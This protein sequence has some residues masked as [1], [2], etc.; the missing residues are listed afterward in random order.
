VN[1]VKIGKYRI[2][3]TL[4][5]GAM[6]VVYKGFD[7]A[8]QR[9]VAIKVLH[10]QN[11][12]G[13]QGKELEQRFQQEAQAAARCSH[14]NIVSIYEYGL[15]EQGAP[16]IAMEYV[17]GVE[18]KRYLK[19][20]QGDL[21]IGQSIEIISQV[22]QALDYAHQHKVIHRDIKPSN[23]ILT[24][25]HQ[26][27]VMDFGVAKLDTSDLTLVGYMVGTPSYMSPEGLRGQTVDG[28]SDLYSVGLVLLELLTGS[29]VK[30]GDRIN[31]QIPSLLERKVPPHP[32]RD[33]LCAL[34]IR[35]LHPEANQ[36]FQT[37]QALLNAI[38]QAMTAGTDA[39]Q[40][41]RDTYAGTVVVQRCAQLPPG[42]TSASS[43]NVLGMTGS[44]S[45]YGTRHS[46]IALSTQTLIQIE[47]TLASH[48][49][50]LAKVLIK[51]SLKST[52]CVKSFAESLAAHIPEKQERQSFLD[53][54]KR[55]G[56]HKNNSAVSRS[57][58]S[59][60]GHGLN[61]SGFNN[62]ELNSSG[63]S[64]SGASYTFSEPELKALEEQLAFYLG[65]LA[66]RMVRRLAKQSRSLEELKQRLSEKIPN[67]SE[68]T[69]FLAAD[70]S[71]TD[72]A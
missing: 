54:L 8:I 33:S 67:H 63:L 36:R 7:D 26:V 19:G 45:T 39:T 18:L 69:A 3:S 60:S 30:V 72:D 50:P 34:L 59:S 58:S 48:V 5:R 53:A 46:N 23:I 4:G 20:E 27:K 9:A 10:E 65:P 62:S 32:I 44:H 61:N 71:V 11:R 42:P 29:R 47:K 2:L 24:E 41:D 70:F 12:Q 40:T 66:G 14:V 13:Q 37:A 55:S 21:S 35:A 52:V 22:L 17:Q 51:K 31:D 15:S 6:G 43:S 16:Y 25:T 64:K 68:R 1:T 49:G 57:S 38:N 56:L 28:R